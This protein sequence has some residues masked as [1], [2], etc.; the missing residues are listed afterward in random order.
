MGFSLGRDSDA[1]VIDAI[2]QRLDSLGE[3]CLA[4]L[5]TSLEAMQAGD[6]TRTVTP[7]TTL[8]PVTGDSRL[9]GVARKVNRIVEQVQ[10]AVEAYNGVRA[11]YARGLGDQSSLD[12]LQ[13]R[14]DSLT[15]NC[16]AGLTEGLAC[17]SKGDLTYGVTP[18]TTPVTGRPG[19]SLGTLA[20]TFNVTL[21]R[22]QSAIGDYNAMRG[23]LSQVIGGVRELADSVAAAAEE[24]TATAQESG[25]AV[26]E[27]SNLMLGVAEGA[28]RQEEMVQGAA[29]VSEEAVA[30]AAEARTVAERGVR[31]T[32]EIASIADQT[33][34]L[35]LNAAIEAAR[36]G[37]QGRGFAVV[38]DEVRKLAES[39]AATV[40]QTRSAFDELSQSIE[41][42]AGYVEKLAGAT[43]EVAVV[44]R[45]TRSA[46]EQ[47]SA[48]AQQ[49][50]AATQEVSAS[51]DS[52]AQTAERLNQAFAR[53]QVEG[54]GRELR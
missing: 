10:A 47:V 3:H 36:A 16:L 33:N 43:R 14:L 39:A 22:M 15:N 7:V 5:V 25:R 42:T 27:I 28:G 49:T 18:V 24:M 35:A 8:I 32:V 31:L 34:L 19:A 6:L 51:S 38:A 48:S 4:D 23:E 9:D 13:E 50:S 11:E 46:T 17:M 37:E 40:D 1:A 20:E 52:L 26:S 29:G 12:G 41:A 45:E 30:L 44:T 21:D 2:N 54:L 53:F